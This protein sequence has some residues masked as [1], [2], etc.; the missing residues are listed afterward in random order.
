MRVLSTL[1]AA[2]LI[3]A[4]VGPMATAQTAEQRVYRVGVLAPSEG[5]I[6]FVR[7]Y[8]LPEL[9]RRGFAVGRN[10]AVIERS[11]TQD[12]M[13]ELARELAETRPDV[14]VAVSDLAIR[15]VTAAAPGI[16]VVMSFGGSDP[17]LSG[18][19]K[20]LSQPGGNITGVVMLAPELDAKRLA[21]LHE[22]V[23]TARRI[24]V[25]TPTRHRQRLVD[26]Q[27]QAE[28]LGVVL[29]FAFADKPADYAPAFDSMRASGAQAL[30]VLSAP[31]FARDAALLSRTATSARLPTMCEWNHMARDGCLIGYGPSNEEL[32]RRTG[33]YVAQILRG[34]P[35]GE[36]PI[37]GPTRFDSAVN[38]RTAASLGLTVPAAILARADEVIE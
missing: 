19:A 11:G 38:L 22:V 7:E 37:E 5:S 14:V 18:L 16:P 24:A 6:A 9:A 10:L 26:L 15:A 12:R 30:L 36:I 33:A 34:I 25:L 3:V 17:V 21:L 13:P 27:H 2:T 4:L 32:R 8:A 35:P 31:E 29:S 28:R 1:A 23:P 20:S